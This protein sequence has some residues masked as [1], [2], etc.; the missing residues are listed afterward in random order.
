[1]KKEIW[2]DLRD[3]KNKYQVSNTGK[4]RSLNY[5]NSG[6]IR[7]LKPKINKQNRL[8]VTL[9]K[10]NIKKI[11]ILSHLILET[12]TGCKLARNEIVEY[13][14]GNSLNIDLYNLYVKTVG[15]KQKE[16]YDKG[17]RFCH[18]FMY[19]RKLMSIRQISEFTDIPEDII[20][21]KLVRNNMGRKKVKPEI[22]TKSV[23]ELCNMVNKKY[24]LLPNTVGSIEYHHDATENSIVQIANKYRGVRQLICGEDKVLLEYLRNIL[25]DKIILNFWCI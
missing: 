2:R 17:N 21:R 9:S 3:Y 14:D 22:V 5:L 19:N 18:K 7:E 25:D 4:I 13:R 1:M 24:N 10:D 6:E 11:Y 16:T 23:N 8:E 12:F 15:D 20:M